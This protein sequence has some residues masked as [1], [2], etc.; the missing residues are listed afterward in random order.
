MLLFFGK[1]V[2]NSPDNQGGTQLPDGI[3][4]SWICQTA[5]DVVEYYLWSALGL[6]LS[7][8]IS[9]LWF[10]METFSL[11][12]DFCP[13][14][15]RYL[16]TVWY[17]RWTSKHVSLPSISLYW[18]FRVTSCYRVSD[19][20]VEPELHWAYDGIL[21]ACSKIGIV[22]SITAGFPLRIPGSEY[23][24]WAPIFNITFL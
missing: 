13:M 15:C 7:I 14:S 23:N 17:P 4:L 16:Q 5:G 24:T 12:L 3:V 6:I 8:F 11:P 18:Y 19:C 9:H 22:L 10:I 2:R 1:S 20:A 21:A